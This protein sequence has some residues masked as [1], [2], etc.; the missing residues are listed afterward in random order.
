MALYLQRLTDWRTRYYTATHLMLAQPFEWGVND[1]VC[2]CAKIVDAITDGGVY[3]FLKANYAWETKEEAYA[4]IA[5]AGGLQALV[6]RVLGPAGRWVDCSTGDV[7]LARS[8]EG[9]EL[10]AIHDG[11]FLLNPTD[12]GLQ[13]VALSTAQVGWRI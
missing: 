11:A 6:E 4:L 8:S 13:S 7:V 12:T 3:D 2:F 1:C 9:S 5:Q 10:L